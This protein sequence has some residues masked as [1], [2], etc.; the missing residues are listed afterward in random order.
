[1]LGQLRK[2]L[3]LERRLN[4]FLRWLQEEAR[5]SMLHMVR[6]HDSAEQWFC[7]FWSG[8]T[9]DLAEHPLFNIGSRENSN[10]QS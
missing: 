8:V 5:N 1:M 9:L 3:I 6:L 4:H 2:K 7:N 10:F